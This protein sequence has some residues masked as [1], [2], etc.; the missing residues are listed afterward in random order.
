M[1]SGC[2]VREQCCVT[3]KSQRKKTLPFKLGLFSSL[4]KPSFICFSLYDIIQIIHTLA[5]A[6]HSVDCETGGTMANDSDMS[7]WSDLLHSSSKLLEQATPSAQF[8]PL[9]VPFRKMKPKKIVISEE[10]KA[11]CHFLNLLFIYLT[12][13]LAMSNFSLLLWKRIVLMFE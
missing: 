6:L 8:P 11:N 2:T 3:D 5:F 7:G 10:T 12:M 9:Q 4:H 13:E 1:P